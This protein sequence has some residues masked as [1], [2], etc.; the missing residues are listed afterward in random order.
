MNHYKFTHYLT[1]ENIHIL[2]NNAINAYIILNKHYLNSSNYYL[3]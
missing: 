1:E 3:N 2:A